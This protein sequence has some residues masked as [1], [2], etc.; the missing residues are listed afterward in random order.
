MPEKIG[1]FFFFLFYPLKELFFFRRESLTSQISRIEVVPAEIRNGAAEAKSYHFE[2][3]FFVA[4]INLLVMMMK[5][6]LL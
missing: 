6:M 3:V 4:K 5:M 1:Q 2:H